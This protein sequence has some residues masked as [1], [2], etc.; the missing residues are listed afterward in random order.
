MASDFHSAESPAREREIVRLNTIRLVDVDF[1]DAAYRISTRTDITDLIRS[2][3]RIG[4][5]VPPLLKP[6]GEKLKIVSG[7]LRLNA[8]QQ[9]GIETTRARLVPPSFNALDCAHCAV[10][11]NSLQRSLNPLE[12]ARGIALLAAAIL[13]E[14]M[15]PA[16]AAA[17]GLSANPDMI[18]KLQQLTR[19]PAIV[20]DGLADGTIGIAMAL[21]LGEQSA[22]FASA[23]AEIF[24]A[25][26]IGLNRQREILGLIMEISARDDVT[27]MD[28][29]RM[30]GIQEI[31]GD[32]ELE[33]PRKVSRIRHWLHHKR[34]P[35][36]A[37]AE[38]HFEDK[39]RQLKL[40]ENIQLRP[41]RFF[42]SDCYTLSIEFSSVEDLQRLLK[43]LDSISENDH[44][45]EVM[46]RA[47][48]PAD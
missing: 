13:D 42:E 25:L 1:S 20:Q 29:I 2:I 34:Y 26:R 9:L 45:K 16:A 41:P 4:V 5:L 15:L 27:P 33:K 32:A 39:R 12:A 31:M 46:S 28:V 8:C 48:R 18:A 24:S 43:Q 6:D 36:L 3:D 11:E 19:L 10:A 40:G 7:F 30:D 44:L 21:A 35:H 47:L 38:D 14:K 17:A 22:D 23:C 37:A